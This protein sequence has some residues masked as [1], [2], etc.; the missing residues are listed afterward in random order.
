MELDGTR[1]RNCVSRFNTIGSLKITSERYKFFGA[2]ASAEGSGSGSGS[3]SCSAAHEDP[4]AGVDTDVEAEAEA[5]AEVLVLADLNIFCLFRLK[6]VLINQSLQ[7]HQ[8]KNKKMED[9]TSIFKTII[10]KTIVFSAVPIGMSLYGIYAFIHDVFILGEK[11]DALLSIIVMIETIY[12]LLFALSYIW[13]DYLNLRREWM[14]TESLRKGYFVTQAK[15]RNYIPIFFWIIHF[16]LSSTLLIVFFDTGTDTSKIL[17]DYPST[18]PSDFIFYT[19][20]VVGSILCFYL[21]LLVYI[22]SYFFVHNI[23]SGVSV[24][25]VRYIIMPKFY[26][27][28]I[29]L[30]YFFL[31]NSNTF[32]ILMTA[33]L[34]F[35]MRT[36]W[37][38][39]KF[40]SNIHF[41]HNSTLKFLENLPI[42]ARLIILG[43]FLFGGFEIIPPINVGFSITYVIGCLFAV[44]E[45]DIFNPEEL[46]SSCHLPV[47]KNTF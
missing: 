39:S 29:F 34:F 18:I 27:M 5:D 21:P 38:F 10:L 2:T 3:D 4:T 15:I 44:M 16:I 11:Y 23:K 41:I 47:S 12:R 45:I 35:V 7:I 32:T 14:R 46:R 42:L 13:V 26:T 31:A 8:N 19:G 6:K 37:T 28:I 43:C 1:L 20:S 40:S 30:M 25:F 9:N 17:N 24:P 36:H 33:T 22:F